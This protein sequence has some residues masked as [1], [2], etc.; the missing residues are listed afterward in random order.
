ME[1]CF[2]LQQESDN[3]LAIELRNK[4]LNKLQNVKTE[5]ELKRLVVSI[6]AENDDQID[7]ENLQLDNG[8][9]PSL[10][11][12][13]ACSI[14]ENQDNLNSVQIEVG[15]ILKKAIDLICN[16][17]SFQI[18]YP[19]PVIDISGDFLNKILVALLR[20]A[21][22]ILLSI[23]K[24]L[25][26]LLVEVCASGL[27]V[28][29][30]YG[31]ASFGDII[32]QSIGDN[33]SQSFINDVFKAFG[34]N[35]DGSP[36]TLDLGEV[37][38]CD[39]PF[40]PVSIGN[41]KNTIQFLDDLS[42]M[43]TP[44][45][46]CSLLNNKA[47]EQTFQVIEEVLKY[48]YP[49]LKSRLNNRTKIAGLFKTLGSKTDPSICDLIENNA[50][51]IISRPDICFTEDTNKLREKLLK[52][53]GLT[54]D[55]VVEQIKKER[56]RNKANLEKISELASKIKSNPNKLF[57]EQQDIFCK[58]GKQG[59]VSLEDMPSLKT[60]VNNSLDTTFNIYA[61][62]MQKNLD[63]FSTTVITTDKVLNVSSPVIAKFTDID[64]IDKDGNLVTV[65]NALNPIFIQRTTSGQF[66]L[67]DDNGN[68]NTDVLLD[69]YD[70][71]KVDDVIN[72]QALLNATSRQELD[73]IDNKNIYILNYNNNQK[74][75]KDVINIIS[76]DNIDNYL[77]TEPDEMSIKFIIPT[78]IGETN[79]EIKLY[80]IGNINNE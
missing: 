51:L 24:K 34:I 60:A 57:G 65:R 15:E 13:F 45:E 49:S 23:I 32:K 59:L 75:L 39:T 17:P 31:T 72:V 66:E 69:Y 5:E 14:Q 37:E 27:S 12:Y 7:I 38:V 41:L 79:K 80:T 56:D 67:S 25:L 50:Q 10:E 73:G 21:I 71:S 43:L 1:V 47:T 30:G 62:V 33:V 16:P 9:I 54:D 44:V 77:M 19:F 52:N 20:L 8:V 28:L 46:V 70:F 6:I 29:N 68:T 61:T 11:N 4:I 74:L 55:E 58:N 53:K 78:K 22:K 42:S 18:P 76:I 3:A 64:T 35:T 26:S 40:D 36:A 2:E 63:S 48:E